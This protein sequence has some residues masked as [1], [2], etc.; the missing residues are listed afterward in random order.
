MTEGLLLSCLFVLVAIAATLIPVFLHMPFAAL[1][2][3]LCCCLVLG[4]GF[5]QAWRKN[6]AAAESHLVNW[7]IL[8]LS[9]F[10]AIGLCLLGGEGHFFYANTDWLY[11]DAVLHDLSEQAWPVLY[12]FHDQ[13]WLLRAP[14]GMYMLP[15][16]VGKAFG[17]PA[18]E[19]ALLVQNSLI[20]TLVFYFLV[21][22]GSAIR[23][24][25]ILIGVVCI[26]SG[27]DSVGVALKYGFTGSQPESDHIEW[28]VGLFQ[29]SSNITQ[30]F[31]VPNH[32]IPGWVFACLFL[33]WKRADIGAGLVLAAIPLFAFWSP[34]SALGMVPFALYVGLSALMRRELTRTDILIV[35]G[36]IAA[37]LPMLLYER[38]NAATVPH[39]FMWDD[40]MF[41]FAY[42][43]FILLEVIPLLALVFLAPSRPPL[44]PPTWLMTLVL[45]AIPFYSFGNFNDFAMRASIPALVILAATVGCLCT[46]RQ[47]RTW[48]GFA[49]LTLML[50]SITGGLEIRRALIRSIN[51]AGSCNLVQI[52][53]ADTPNS[54]LNHYITPTDSLPAWLHS[55]TNEDSA[56][57]TETHC[58]PFSNA[59]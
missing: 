46:L 47:S 48:T 59:H 14:L 2:S 35:L 41:P 52:W 6:R 37:A 21:P 20:F 13:T 11:R 9:A 33:K 15:A 34:L 27:W 53:Q 39:R 55:N 24:A 8:V 12:R 50:G 57:K 56:A 36:A 54:P 18:A 4:V 28:W 5:A 10:F 58:G 16:L 51:P 1:I 22:A 7:R 44:Q 38:L 19:M 32:A 43:L 3:A 40:P 26:F 17:F 45:L 31:W 25:L 30:I 42:P 49:I 29:Y 23:S